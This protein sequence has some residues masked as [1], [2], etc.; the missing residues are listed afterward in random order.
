MECGEVALSPACEVRSLEGL[1][2][3][4]AF[5]PRLEADWPERRKNRCVLPFPLPTV[6]T[7]EAALPGGQVGPNPER[8]GGWGGGRERVSGGEWG[9]VGWESELSC[10]G[11]THSV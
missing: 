9:R 3:E 11:V 6:K 4:G 7:P 2:K 5:G 10:V 1:V 8:R